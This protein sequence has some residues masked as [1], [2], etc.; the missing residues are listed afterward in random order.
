MEQAIDDFAGSGNPVDDTAIDLAQ[1]SKAKAAPSNIVASLLLLTRV[2]K[3][4]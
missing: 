3:A 2:H 1:R 4:K